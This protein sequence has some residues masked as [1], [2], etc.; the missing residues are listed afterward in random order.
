MS[1]DAESYLPSKHYG[2][3]S[4][5]VFVTF[6]QWLSSR[7]ADVTAGP[8]ARHFIA[9]GFL[10]GVVDADGN[11]QPMYTRWNGPGRA[12]DPTVS[13]A[14]QSWVTAPPAAAAQALR[15][16]TFEGLHISARHFGPNVTQAEYDAALAAF[17]G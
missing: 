7:S 5:P 3:H 2:A 4:D 12:N 9:N 11:F 8:L 6:A 13:D 14:V 16:H 15:W 1:T 10:P 17:R